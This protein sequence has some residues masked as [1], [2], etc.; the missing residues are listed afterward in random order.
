MAFPEREAAVLLANCARH[1]CVCH[2]WC[3]FRIELHHIQARA[4][5]GGDEIDNAIPV[6]FDCHAEIESKGPRGRKYSEH[7][8]REHRRLWLQAIADHPDLLVRREASQ[9]EAGPL[10]ALLSE[11]R[12]NQ[13]LLTGEHDKW[14]RP[15]NNQQFDRAINAN[16]FAVVDDTTREAVFAAYGNIGQYCEQYRSWAGHPFRGDTYNRIE[17]ALNDKRVAMRSLVATAIAKL[18][19]VLGR[20][21]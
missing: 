6:C 20:T 15:L 7:E 9:S 16:A 1:C 2:R 3:G 8:L 19:A 21:H 12:Y 5:G 10:E 18:D 14:V 11:L 17:H 13:S 4:D